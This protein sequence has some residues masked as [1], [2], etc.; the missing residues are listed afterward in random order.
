VLCTPQP[1]RLTWVWRS[2][3]ECNSRHSEER[4]VWGDGG[5]PIAN[6]QAVAWALIATQLFTGF[7]DITDE[8]F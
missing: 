5:Y 4:K 7:V 2:K 8:G 6:T 1:V 3:G